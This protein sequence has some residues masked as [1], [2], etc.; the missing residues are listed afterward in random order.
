MILNSQQRENSTESRARAEEAHGSAQGFSPQR[1]TRVRTE[2]TTGREVKQQGGTF[3]VP[4]DETRCKNQTQDQSKATLCPVRKQY[5]TLPPGEKTVIVN[6]EYHDHPKSPK[7]PLNEQSNGYKKKFENENLNSVADEKSIASPQNW[8]NR[9]K[10][11]HNTQSQI[12]YS[13]TIIS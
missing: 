1:E 11:E 13:R 8:Q 12:K 5:K 4:H 3:R 2:E 7:T 9:R 6:W 10:Q